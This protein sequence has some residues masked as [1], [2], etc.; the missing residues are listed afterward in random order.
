MSGAG[1]KKCMPTTRAGVAT[2]DAISV[3]ESAEVFVA[4]MASGADDRL[5]LR[6]ERELRVELLDDGFDD[7][8]ASVE[9]R[10]AR[11][12]ATA[13]RARLARPRRVMR[14]LSTLRWRK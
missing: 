8:V 2:A 4:R 10:R 3:T 11:S 5:E 13:A 6:E 9:G 7:E 12:S 14:S 1:L